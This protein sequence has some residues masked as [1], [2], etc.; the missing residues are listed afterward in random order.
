MKTFLFFIM[1]IL[2]GTYPLLAEDIDAKM[3][4]IREA[5]PKERVKLMN[6]LKREIASLNQTQRY[7]AI[8]A[9]RFQKELKTEATQ[10]IQTGQFQNAQQ[11][12]QNQ[13]F[14]QTQVGSQYMKGKD[15]NKMKPH[16]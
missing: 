8:N 10:D 15:T 16:K 12:M 9:L 5:P 7:E 13:N 2:F 1:L 11:N 14:N 3:Q 6:A 4:K